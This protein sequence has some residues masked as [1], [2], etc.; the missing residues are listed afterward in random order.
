VAGRDGVDDPGTDLRQLCDDHGQGQCQQGA[1]FFQNCTKFDCW[2]S[3]ISKV[4]G[5]ALLSK[6]EKGENFIASPLSQKA[7]LQGIDL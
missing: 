2:H 4:G 3:G 6:K 1:I 5:V 7:S